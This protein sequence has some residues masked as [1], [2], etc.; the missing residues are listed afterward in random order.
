[1]KNIAFISVLFSV[2]F[3]HLS[4]NAYDN[5]F[6]QSSLNIGG[7]NIYSTSPTSSN[8]DNDESPAIKEV[9]SYTGSV[10]STYATQPSIVINNNYP[11]PYP[12]YYGGNY[13]TTYRI[14]PYYPYTYYPHNT[15]NIGFSAGVR[16]NGGGNFA[17]N[18]SGHGYNYG[19][20]S[21]SPIYTP[22]AIYAHRPPMIPP[23]NNINPPPKPGSTTAGFNYIW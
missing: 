5:S 4:V 7:D 9:R 14:G 11:A 8:N 17:Y 1:M 16:T 10:T 20:T 18:Y 22:N 19:V 13:V 15:T 21:S 23:H 2:I 3:M 6:T 12:Y